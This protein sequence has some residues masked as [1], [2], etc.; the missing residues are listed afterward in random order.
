ML[1]KV[2]SDPTPA[3]GKSQLCALVQSHAVL[4]AALAMPEEMCWRAWRWRALDSEG[5]WTFTWHG[6]FV[7]TRVNSHAGC[8]TETRQALVAFLLGH[9]PTHEFAAGRQPP[10]TVLLKQ[11]QALLPPKGG[12]TTSASFSPACP[13]INARRTR[14]MSIDQLYR[15]LQRHSRSTT[16]LVSGCTAGTSQDS[17]SS[18]AQAGTESRLGGRNDIHLASSIQHDGGN[19]S[20]TQFRNAL[21][22]PTDFVVHTPRRKQTAG[23]KRSQ[24][25]FVRCWFWLRWQR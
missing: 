16:P 12:T 11:Q 21:M 6:L 4:H 22:H 3:A 8:N 24:F 15:L 7:R 9:L 2:A 1:S 10:S 13:S 25:P 17:A 19:N 18:T 20:M 5:A 14:V 23:K